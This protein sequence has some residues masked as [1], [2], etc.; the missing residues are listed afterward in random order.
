MQNCRSWTR[1]S[2]SNDGPTHHGIQDLYLMY[3]IP[4]FEIFNV[5]DN[6]LANQLSKKLFNISGQNMLDLTKVF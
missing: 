2:F 5:A 4:E 6:N 3:L 1:F